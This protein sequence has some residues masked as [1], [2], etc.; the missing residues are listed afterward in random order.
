MRLLNSNTSYLTC[1]WHAGLVALGLLLGGCVSPVPR[2]T[3]ISPPEV[4]APPA[5]SNT[6]AKPQQQSVNVPIKNSPIMDIPETLK[7]ID[8]DGRP[9]KILFPKQESN[10][11]P[12]TKDTIE[13]KQDSVLNV[14]VLLPL[15]GSRAALGQ[16]IL[17]GIEF[18]AFRYLQQDITV[19]LYDTQAS[20]FI[21]K[22]RTQQAIDEGADII[23]GPLFTHTS[24][25]AMQI[26]SD[27][28]VPLLSFSNNESLLNA[29]TQEGNTNHNTIILGISPYEELRQL[30]F[31]ANLEGIKRL[32]LIAPDNA[33]GQ[34]IH[35]EL[36]KLLPESSMTLSRVA[37]Y[38]PKSF[39]F[40]QIV[41]EISDY[42]ERRIAYQAEVQRLLEQQFGTIEQIKRHLNFRETLGEVPFDA[43]I[44]AANSDDRLRTIA[45]QMEFYEVTP[46]QVKFM[47]LRRWQQFT[48]LSREPALRNAW[49]VGLGNQKF[50]DFTR[51]FYAIYGKNP[52]TLS[53][54]GFDVLS[55]LTYFQSQQQP[56]PQ[57]L[58]QHRDGFEGALGKFRFRDN[59]SVER[60]MAIYR[61]TEDAPMV[62]LE[63]ELTKE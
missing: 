48:N 16:Q 9:E 3:V 28:K 39:D 1:R 20:G 41:Q 40:T 31:I 37:L 55:V 44:I 24:Q 34:Q 50:T 46:E 25:Q 23:L 57:A 33:Y 8:S 60:G 29:A 12:I 52:T 2:G 51:D 42:A 4:Q 11:R 49:F 18:A 17:E 43:V 5:T 53:A 32:S 7:T 54:L 56:L 45:A 62:L 14:A 22:Q 30:V 59:G 15:S 35:A 26:A 63:A 61:I 27:A 19:R 21:S 36:Q 47:G 6:A 38:D 58:F 13:V 10:Q